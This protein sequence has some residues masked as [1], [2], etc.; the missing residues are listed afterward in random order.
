MEPLHQVPVGKKIEPEHGGKVRHGPDGFGEV[1][2]RIW[3]AAPQAGGKSV[4]E[5]SVLGGISTLFE[6]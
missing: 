6:R 1:A 4:G 2:S 5:G 3:K